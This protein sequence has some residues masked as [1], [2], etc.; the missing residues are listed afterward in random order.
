MTTSGFVPPARRAILSSGDLD[1]YRGVWPAYGWGGA[2][3]NVADDEGNTPLHLC[4]S[5]EL[6]TAL[7]EAEADPNATN[8]VT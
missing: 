8:K 7:L 1:V 6:M 4:N 3:P 2:N 5:P